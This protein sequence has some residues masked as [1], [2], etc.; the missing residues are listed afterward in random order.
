MIRNFFLIVS[1]LCSLNLIAQ[2]DRWQQAADYE[3][4]IDMDV[5][6][7]RFEGIQTINYTNNSPDT[8]DRIFYHLYFNAFQP[9]SMMDVRSRTISDPDKRVGDRIS[10]LT[11]REIGFQEV[12]SL[13]LNGAACTYITEGTILEVQLPTPI[14]PGKTVK[15][16]MEFLAQVPLQIRRSGR[17]NKEGIRYSMTQWYPKLCNYD[18]QGWHANPYIGREFYGIWGNF[19]VKISIN[20]KYLVGGS[21]QLQNAKKIGMGYDGIDKAKMSLKKK[22]T[23]HFVAEKVHDFAWAAD[24]D[25]THLTEMAGE[26]EFH[27]LFQDGP[28][29][30]ENWNKLH[31]ALEVALPYIN[32]R[33]GKYPYPVY[34]IMQGGDGGME[35]AMCTLI[36]GERTFGSLVGVSIHELMHS[37]YQMVLGTNEA[38]YP[39]MDEGFTSYATAEVMNYLRAKGVLEGEPQKDA[40]Y[41]NIRNFADFTQSGMEEP[42]ATHADHYTTNTAY[43]AGSY[44]K[45][46]VFLKQLEYIIGQEAFDKTMLRYFNEWKF[47]HPNTNDFI[48]V[49]EKQSGLEL[50][51][52]KE[53]FINSTH[54]IDYGIAEVNGDDK[55]STIKLE[56]LGV[57]PMPID[58]LIETT[59]G[60]Q[61]LYTIPLRIMR[62]EKSNEKFFESYNVAKDWPW[63]NAIYDL[64]VDIPASKI[65]AVVIDP[66]LR[67]VDINLEN[68]VYPR[69][70]GDEGQ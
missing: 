58:V 32:K 12:K 9:G 48:R 24:P 36:T 18:Y 20:K 16:K 39:W 23:W 69:L 27:Y 56:K 21:G 6:T 57:M 62:G 70:N 66:T 25:Y 14:L 31:E 61:I 46:S 67:M 34:Y 47:K 55:K 45:G 44:T 42:L 17:D 35:Y 52:F 13:T 33:F 8:L 59:D 54:T 65:E 51:W 64:E 30:N 22:R 63:T 4:E 43:G 41:N 49:A 3:M 50:D 29:T 37:W 19:D 28:K 40:L 26:T 68:N 38:L 53:Y 7:D 5:E 60:E 2:T 1:I 10:K 11:P 15:L